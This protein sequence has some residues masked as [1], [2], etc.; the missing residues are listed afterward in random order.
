M[1]IGLDDAAIN[2]LKHPQR[3]LVL[4]RNDL[5]DCLEAVQRIAGVDPLGE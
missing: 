2:L 4:G 1:Q 3:G 5:S